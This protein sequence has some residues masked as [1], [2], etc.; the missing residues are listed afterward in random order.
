[1]LLIDQTVVQD[2]ID[3]LRGIITDTS[4]ATP[5]ASSELQSGVHTEEIEASESS[6]SEGYYETLT[7]PACSTS[8]HAC[9]N[10][11]PD[12]EALRAVALS[13]NN[14]FADA[15]RVDMSGKLNLY[16]PAYSGID[17]AS[18]CSDKKV[19]E[20]SGSYYPIITCA[21]MLA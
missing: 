7:L 5:S 11:I 15:V 13:N 4:K 12:L 1:M 21:T 18:I 14:N 9:S 19:S 17:V 20:C 10:A 6:S 3:E 2:L 16:P 8:S